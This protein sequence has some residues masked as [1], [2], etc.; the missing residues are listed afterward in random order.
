[1]GTASAMPL[2]L[3]LPKFFAQVLTAAMYMQVVPMPM[4]TKATSIG[5]N[6]QP[7]P[8]SFVRGPALYANAATVYPPPK[9]SPAMIEGTCGPLRS[10]RKPKAATGK[11]IAISAEMEIAFPLEEQTDRN[12]KIDEMPDAT[13]QQIRIR[14]GML[15]GGTD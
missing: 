5:Q 8:S 13:S 2:Y 15:H 9:S 7:E 3:P 1:M 4:A 6:G 12:Y 14:E 11:Y 10:V